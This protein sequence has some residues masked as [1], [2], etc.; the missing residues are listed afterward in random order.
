MT[1]NKKILYYCQSLVGVGH[2]TCSLRIMDALRLCNIEVDLIY[3]G[4]DAAMPTEQPGL[5]T[6]RLPTLLHDEDS[7]EFFSPDGSNRIEAIWDD[8]ARHRRFPANALRR[9]RRR[10]LSLRPPPLQER[11]RLLVQRG[12]RGAGGAGDGQ[13]APHGRLGT[14]A[15]P[16]RVRSRR[17]AAH[18]TSMRPRCDRPA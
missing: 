7:G 12:A 8:R 10:V 11:D 2:L 6:L 15:H 14:Q 17:P 9:Q 13:R 3:G 1:R 16:Y 5:R 4:L 18:P